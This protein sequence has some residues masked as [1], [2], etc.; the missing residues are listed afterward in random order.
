[1]LPR[2]IVTAA[3][4]VAGVVM[5]TPAARAQEDE[6]PR[7]ASSSDGESIHEEESPD[8]EQ[9]KKEKEKASEAAAGRKGSLVQKAN[10]PVTPAIAINLQN[11]FV[12][13]LY[14]AGGVSN[15]LLV[16]GVVPI[17]IGLEQVVRITLP[18]PTASTATDS[19]Q[20]AGLGD[21]QVF[22]IVMAT[23][24][25]AEVQFGV[26]PQATFPTAVPSEL[27][28]GKWQIGAASALMW[29]PSK[30]VMLGTLVTWQVSVA[31]TSGGSSRRGQ[32]QLTVQPIAVLQLEAGFYLRSTG[33][34]TFNF[35]TGDYAVP[36]GVG[37]GK[38]VKLSNGKI[39]VNFYLEPQFTVLHGG[40]GQPA[41]Q[42][43][44]G[45]NVQFF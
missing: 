33:N 31:S 26:G 4:F 14:G 1:M 44:G 18:L 19:D 23:G 15:Q 3:R 17:Q 35:L 11:Y 45:L 22:D 36:F 30:A 5:L 20:K 37:A 38:V 32:D 25:E 40:T 16:R 2:P 8:A 13:A 9:E 21:L 29:L 10:N 7:A 34:S 27:G 42:L 41:T 39:A 28:A 24:P 12:P 43:L 6:T